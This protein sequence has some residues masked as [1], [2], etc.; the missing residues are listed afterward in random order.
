MEEI[1]KEFLSLHGIADGRYSCNVQCRKNLAGAIYKRVHDDKSFWKS[2]RGVS[3]G[4]GRFQR[5][6]R[7]LHRLSDEVQ[8]D[9]IDVS[10]HFIDVSGGH[11]CLTGDPKRFKGVFGGISDSFKGFTKGS[12]GIIEVFLGVLEGLRSQEFSVVFQDISHGFQQ[13]SEA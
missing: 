1:P 2:Y 4:F 3:G 10:K 6:C 12:G 8:G 7:G 11:S 5:P 13:V 9:S